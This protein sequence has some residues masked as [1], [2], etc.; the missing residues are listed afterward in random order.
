MTSPITR[1]LTFDEILEKLCTPDA[2][3][4]WSS[5]SS[6]ADRVISLES[7]DLALFEDFFAAFGGSEPVQG[8]AEVEA[9]VTAT[10]R[11]TSEQVD[12]GCMWLRRNDGPLPVDDVF[13]GLSLPDCPYRSAPSDDGRWMQVW[14]EHDDGPLFVY[15]NDAC[16]FRKA[17]DWRS[18][19]VTLIYRGSLR[20]REDLIFFHA[21][22]LAISGQGVLIVGRKKGGKSTTSLALAA[23]G[24]SLL[25]DSCAC[26]S[27]S[28]GELVPF[29]RPVG[30]REGPRSRA[31]E[32][33]L[34]ERSFRA[35]E[36]DT[37]LRVDVGSLL[38][39]SPFHAVPAT[40]IF[41]LREFAD[42]TRIEKLKNDQSE[43]AN[44]RPIY[45]SFVNAPHTQRVFELIRLLSRARLYAL[46]P[47]DPD[48]TARSIE[49]VMA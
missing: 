21:S 41:F 40:A 45:S 43:I 39:E 38:P 7:D 9:F 30:I 22:A 19:L 36:R 10:V 47:G 15:R 11:T 25:A 18:K 46:W 33:A 24:H 5:A 27:P 1:T 28:T 16:L 23:R 34:T 2:P 35:V 26:Y 17:A 12:Y 3:R 44:L 48:H 8:P 6:L 13:F 37:S 32:N 42:C 49:E 20:L 4:L 31:V 29:R 14:L